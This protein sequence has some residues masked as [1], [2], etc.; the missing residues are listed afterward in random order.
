VWPGRN[1]YNGT[2]RARGNSLKN[3]SCSLHPA[4]SQLA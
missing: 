2:A 4:F 3:L 1:K